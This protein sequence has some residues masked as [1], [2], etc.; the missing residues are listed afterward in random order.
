MAINVQ[1]VVA[2]IS[3]VL[4]NASV[5]LDS[6]R[7]KIKKDVSTLTSVIWKTYAKMDSVEIPQ[8]HT[9]V[10]A[11]QELSSNLVA[12]ILLTFFQYVAL[13]I[14]ADIFESSFQALNLTVKQ[15]DVKI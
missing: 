8:D 1:T 15:A 7:L 2:Q 9:N 4:I 3:L 5:I 13:I 11:T 6:K 14:S 12:P 10:T